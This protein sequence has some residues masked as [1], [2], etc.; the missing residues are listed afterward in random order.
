MDIPVLH[1]TG[2]FDGCAPGEFH[3]Y[4]EMR[5]RSPAATGRP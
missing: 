1:V 2:W 5:E 3:H 4:H